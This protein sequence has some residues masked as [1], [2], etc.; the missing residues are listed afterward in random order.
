M[1]QMGGPGFEPRSMRPGSEECHDTVAP[2]DVPDEHPAARPQGPV[3]LTE[4][5]GRVRHILEDL[6][7]QRGVELAI[8]HGQRRGIRFVESHIR[9]PL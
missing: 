6:H 7:A 5:C 8:A 2:I 9:L 1:R 4:R 3:E